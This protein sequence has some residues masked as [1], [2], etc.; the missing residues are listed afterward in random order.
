V[1][2]NVF[3]GDLLVAH[4]RYHADLRSGDLVEIAK[5]DVLFVVSSLAAAPRHVAEVWVEDPELIE[6]LYP[7]KYYV[8]A[9][10]RDCLVDLFVMSDEP[11]CNVIR[12]AS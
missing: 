10:W 3:P 5:G 4:R 2:V 6:G 1:R 12:D 7:D 9:L 8:Q 11:F